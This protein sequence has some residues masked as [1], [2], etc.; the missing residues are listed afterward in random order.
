M[1]FRKIIIGLLLCLTA[2]R[3]D[4]EI[5]PPETILVSE[6]EFTSI[7]GFYLLNEGNM[8][9]N[10]ASL[11]YYDYPTSE[12]RRNIFGQANPSV[13]KDLGD[14]GN[15]IQIYGEKLYAVI[16]GSNKVE[17]M[18]AS[19]ARRIGQIDI[20]NCRYIR[21]HEAYAYVTSYAGPVEVNPDYSQ[22]G[23]VAK[24][25]TATLEIVARCL[26]GYQPDE[27]AVAGNK[28]YVAN[29]GGYRQPNYENTISVI[30]I[31]SF[32]ETKRIPVAYNLQRLR[33]DRHGMLWATSRGDYKTLLPGL[34]WVDIQKEVLIDSLSVSVTALHLDGD[35]LYFLGAST[36]GENIYGIVDVV[37][38]EIVSSKI[39]SDG[40]EKNIRSPYGITVNPLTKDIYISDAKD[41]IL[42]G[43]LYCFDSYGKQKWYVR[44]GDIPA[45]FV[46]RGIKN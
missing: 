28:I 20:P 43:T 18:E 34:F 36:S 16:N 31:S 12:Y 33:V 23:F 44:T 40:T 30:D 25:D 38:K 11:D 37:K 8:G 27:L 1:H 42:P 9:M 13:I 14:V 10:K 39:I 22:R 3:E 2:C 41:H 4:I 45:H 32:T 26:V 24:V 15:D 21:F 17:V 19:T 46:F 7:Q 5:F 35:S 6:P 29:S